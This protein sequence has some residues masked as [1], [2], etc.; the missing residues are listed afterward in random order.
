MYPI[1]SAVRVLQGFGLNDEHMQGQRTPPST[2]IGDGF[3]TVS[4]VIQKTKLSRAT[5]C[6]AMKSGD[7]VAFRFGRAVRID[8][9][10]L[11]A[12]LAANRDERRAA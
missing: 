9:N 5:I 11:K 1:S 3:L 8:P 4:D 12:W 6:R 7:L 10:D 2:V